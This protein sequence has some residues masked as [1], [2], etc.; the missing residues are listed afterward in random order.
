MMALQCDRFR[1]VAGIDRHPEAASP[2][3]TGADEVA[4]RVA[5]LRG[6]D[7]GRRRCAAHRSGLGSD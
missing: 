3:A 6:D 7:G 4:S 2:R 5:E 1:E